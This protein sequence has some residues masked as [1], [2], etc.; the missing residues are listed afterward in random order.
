LAAFDNGSVSL[1]RLDVSSCLASSNVLQILFHFT[2]E[3]KDSPFDDEIRTIVP[4]TQQLQ[5]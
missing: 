1:A 5:K 3:I 2:N 4:F